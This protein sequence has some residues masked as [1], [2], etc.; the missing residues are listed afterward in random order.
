MRKASAT[1]PIATADKV[2]RKTK[3]TTKQAVDGGTDYGRRGQSQMY[4]YIGL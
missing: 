4:L 1:D 3:L 2:F